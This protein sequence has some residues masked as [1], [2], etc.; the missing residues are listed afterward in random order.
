MCASFA[1]QGGLCDDFLSHLMCCCCAL[2]QEW[3]EV[4]IRGVHGNV[5]YLLKLFW[6]RHRVP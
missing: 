2:V 1:K 5:V 3:R 4:K 6:S